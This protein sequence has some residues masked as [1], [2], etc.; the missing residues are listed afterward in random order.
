MTLLTRRTR[1]RGSAKW[2]DVIS[3]AFVVMVLVF[4]L[5]PLLYALMTSVQPA[6]VARSRTPQFVFQPTLENFRNLFVE[7]TFLPYFVNSLTSS[8]G[9]MAMS[10][11]IGLPAAYVM[12]RRTFS[13]Y[14]ALMITLLGARALPAIGVAIP[15]FIIFTEINIIDQPIALILAYLP[16]NV[17]LV[18]WLMRGYF[19]AVP[20]SLDEAAA[21]DGCSP[22]VT[23]IRVIL[24]VSKSGV[25]A[26]AVFAFLYGWNNFFFPLVLTQTKSATVP[27]GLTQFVGEYVVNWGQIMAGV[28]MLT[29]PLFFITILLRRHMTAGLSQGAIRE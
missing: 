18:T 29:I 15:F 10:L 13:G 11:L 12:S 9:A 2:A 14:W 28:V 3:A 7:H 24:P 5:S 6:A 17:A 16:Y 22:L 4:I 20:K 21:L 27:L 19:D 26:S 8:L 25:L 1:S 23:L